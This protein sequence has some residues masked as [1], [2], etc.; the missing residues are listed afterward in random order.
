MKLFPIRE[1]ARLWGV[2][3]TDGD[4]AAEDE[5]L[6]PE[7]VDEPGPLA[8]DSDEEFELIFDEEEPDDADEDLTF[9]ED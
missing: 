6:V 1:L 5:V 4:S 2:D 7:F 9:D 3:G 8:A